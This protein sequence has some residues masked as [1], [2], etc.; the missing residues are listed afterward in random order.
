MNPSDSARR[1]E[2]LL[3]YGTVTELDETRALVRVKSGNITTDWIKWTE[4]ATFGVQT[5]RAP[6]VGST[7]IL[8]SPSG[9]T[10][11]AIFMPC[12]ITT[13][14]SSSKDEVIIQFPDG[15]KFIYN[16]KSSALQL[17]GMKSINIEANEN[18]TFNTAKFN[19][20]AESQ[21][22]L[23]TPE[24]TTPGQIK[25]DGDQIAGTVSQMKHLHINV[26]SGNS[27]TGVPG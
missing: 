15:A 21:V 8:L 10:T 25:S 11:T 5:W 18:I 24:T 26:S 7:G 23:N 19:V 6:L 1:I 27:K 4:F 9:E 22:T 16:Y 14:I 17:L 20:N 3:K 13:P 2:S 12:V